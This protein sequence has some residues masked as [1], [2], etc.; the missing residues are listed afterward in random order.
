M[1]YDTKGTLGYKSNA[2][3]IAEL[4]KDGIVMMR[5]YL[6]VLSDEVPNEHLHYCQEMRIS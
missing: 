1:A 2:K 3:N 5:Q 6:E 4:A